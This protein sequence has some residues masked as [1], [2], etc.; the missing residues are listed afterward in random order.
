MGTGDAK[1]SL[2]PVPPEGNDLMAKPFLE[3]L[4]P[5]IHGKSGTGIAVVVVGVQF[6]YGR[7]GLSSPRPVFYM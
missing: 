4:D 2:M 3:P 5:T 6:A 1:S 7:G